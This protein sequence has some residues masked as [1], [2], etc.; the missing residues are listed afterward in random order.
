MSRIGTIVLGG[1]AWGLAAAG[2]LSLA[3]LPGDFGHSLCGPWGCF[4]PLQALAAMHLFWAVALVPPVAWGLTGAR[5]HQLQRAGLLLFLG[6]LLGIVVVVG[7]DL[8]TWLAW[9]PPEFQSCWP[10]R[11]LYTL[12]TLSDV[13]LVQVLLAGA[14]CWSVGKRRQQRLDG[15]A[16]GRAAVE[17]AAVGPPA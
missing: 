1:V 17:P 14:I 10:G 3:S 2:A 7:R 4:P 11:A 5:P 8:P 6:A 13:P 16:A 15:G 12:V 9:A